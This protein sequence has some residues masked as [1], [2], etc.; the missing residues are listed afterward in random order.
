M[1][2]AQAAQQQTSLQTPIILVLG[3]SLSASF[4]I[5]HS[6][7]WVSLLEQKL[8]NNYYNYHIVNASISGETTHGGLQRLPKLLAKYQPRLVII[9][10]GGND[11]LRGL[12]IEM[13][14]SN[15][16]TMISKTAETHADILLVG[17]R[18]PPNYGKLYTESFYQMYVD[19]GQDNKIPVVP[20]LLDGIATDDNLMQSDGIHPRVE[21][22]PLILEN[23]WNKLKPLLAQNLK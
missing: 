2:T 8:I 21:A 13:I 4:G 9:E 20:F 7:G 22:Q 17:M 23:V 14:K 18:L 12:S 16:Q 19:L 11:G 3:D 1:G 10:L 6:N 15:L 5:D